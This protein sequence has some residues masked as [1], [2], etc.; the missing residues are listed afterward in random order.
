MSKGYQI[1]IWKKAPFL[2]IVLPLIF[3]IIV[4][5]YFQIPV[6]LLAATAFFLMIFFVLF[7]VLPEA[8][9]FRWRAVQGIIISLFILVC[10]SLI[11][12]KKDIRN[13]LNWYGKNIDTASFL[14]AR[15][16]EPPVEKAKSYKALVIVESI[17][18]KGNQQKTD[19]KLLVYFAKGSASK[20]LKY[21]DRIIFG[22]QLQPIKNSGNPAAFDYAR[23]CAFQQIFHQVFL[24]E[25][26]W[27][28][29]RENN[30]VSFM[31]IIFKSK[32]YILQSLQKYIPGADE[33]SVAKALL[34]GYRIDLDK[35][36]V[37]AYS[38]AGVVHLIAI[39]GM[40]LALIYFFLVWLFVKIP[41][42]KKSRFTKLVLILFCL[43]FFSLLTGAPASV[44]RA[45]VMFSFIAIGDSFGKRN[46]IYN[47]LAIS[48]FALLC[49]DPYKLWD[50]GFQLSYLAVLSIVVCQKYIYDWFY[51]KNKI[52]D[53]GWKLA[54]VS[55]AAQ[56]FTLPICIY[57]F[58]Q[59]PLLFL[60]SNMIAIPLSTI[61]LW[62]SILIVIFS[63][64][65]LLAIVLGKILW[66]LVW[67]LN[68]SVFIINLIPFSLWDGLSISIIDTILL[69][70]FFIAILL[71]IIK[72]NMVSFKFAIAFIFAF[73]FINTFEKLEAQRQKKIVV[74]NVNQHKAIDF[75]KGN[76]YYFAG[77][78]EVV[79]D[80]LLMNYNI[81]PARVAFLADNQSS[82]PGVFY[83]K[84]NFFQFY[85]KKLLVVD[86]PRLYHPIAKKISVDYIVIS[87]NPQI[88]ISKLADIFDCGVYIFDA[89]NAPWKIEK[90]KKECE[91]LH[92]RSHSVSEQGAFVTDL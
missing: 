52:V 14:V 89:S 50:V 34:I 12:W 61:A 77:D 70:C 68:H 58:H 5:F 35:D 86:S 90:W 46:S 54:S 43:W 31:N 22:K 4:Q 63:P 78:Q 66:A 59:F 76:Q 82:M 26:E 51:F 27:I 2:R 64:I 92:L 19:G 39:S 85:N 3:G 74:Y 16:Q 30:R 62:G 60:L 28:L 55:L 15:I 1:Y 91:E 29:L 87:K 75:I 24:K 7:S 37:Q 49:Y 33:S 20:K 8:K 13:G 38:N 36:L 44:L 73:T 79:S 72:K 67:L 25:N 53:A 23:Y 81:K 56:I 11:T 83:K 71:W 9:R 40:H 18:N 45:A 80:K 69:Y 88:K 57:Y 65:P 42:V 21:G 48:A 47:S 17:A 84:N 6:V 41:V 32:N 10:G